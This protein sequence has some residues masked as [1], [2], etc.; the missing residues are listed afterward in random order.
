MGEGRTPSGLP[1]PAVGSRNDAGP[2]PVRN[3]RGPRPAPGPGKAQV[4]RRGG[5]DRC[6]AGRRAPRRTNVGVPPAGFARGGPAAQA[7]TP[8]RGEDAMER[9]GSLP[10]LMVAGSEY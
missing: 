9:T 5:D 7:V 8:G 4:D 6:A 3:R 2:T 10:I 1:S